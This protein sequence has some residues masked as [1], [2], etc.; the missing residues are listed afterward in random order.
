MFIGS[1]FL[2]DSVTEFAIPRALL[3]L[4]IPVL[5]VYFL[6]LLLDCG[7]CLVLFALFDEID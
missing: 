1:H 7:E 3:R 4:D 5:T 2:Y 6:A